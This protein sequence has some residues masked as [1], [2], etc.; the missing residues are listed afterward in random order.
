MKTPTLTFFARL[1]CGALLATLAACSGVA[2]NPETP[3]AEVQA[4]APATPVKVAMPAPVKA[5]TAVS[6]TLRQQLVA[7]IGNAA[8]DTSAQCRTLAVGHRACGGPESYLAYSTKTGDA[9][10]MQRIA[11]QDTAA[12][13]QQDTQSGGMSTCQMVMDPGATCQ[14]GRCVSGNATDAALPTR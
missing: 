12:R 14:A 10:K 8:C 13:K 3:A 4:S 2:G 9:A 7:E 5:A 6:S 11:A 1:G